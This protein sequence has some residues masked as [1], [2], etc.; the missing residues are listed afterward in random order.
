MFTGGIGENSAYIRERV[1]AELACLGCFL[2]E[3]KN[4]EPSGQAAVV[5]TAEEHA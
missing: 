4:N 5:S 3:A 2:D 1:V